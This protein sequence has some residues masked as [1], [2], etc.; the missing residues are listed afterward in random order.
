MIL[1]RSG[2]NKKKRSEWT[3]QQN[4]DWMSPAGFSWENCEAH[5]VDLRYP[6]L[7][8]FSP[9]QQREQR[10]AQPLLRFGIAM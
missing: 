2:A 5:G 9:N 8:R 10:T 7:A 3:K 6:L 4:P 1:A